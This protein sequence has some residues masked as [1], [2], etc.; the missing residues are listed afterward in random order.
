MQTKY[1]IKCGS[2]K[3]KHVTAHV[4][5]VLDG[6]TIAVTA[7]WCN[8]CYN[9]HDFGG[10]NPIL[11]KY[12]TGYYGNWKP[13]MSLTGFS[14]NNKQYKKLKRLSNLHKKNKKYDLVNL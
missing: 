2:D 1:C 10:E 5:L 4:N 14:K 11:K 7:S 3:I 8:N 6:K 12:L 9:D 13:F